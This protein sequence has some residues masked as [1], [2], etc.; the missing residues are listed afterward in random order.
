MSIDF[1]DRLEAD[2]REA[3]ERRGQPSPR[4]PRRDPRP[5]LKALAVAAVL[6]LLVVAGARLANRDSIERSA[7]PTPTP[8]P[9]VE[10]LG[11]GPLKAAAATS[12]DPSSL[13][14]FVQRLANA[15]A[16]EFVAPRNGRPALADPSLGTVVLYA[17]GA[18]RAA[19]LVARSAGIDRTRALM[20]AD[21][22]KLSFNVRDAQVVIVFGPDLQERTLEQS[23]N[24]TPAGHV[25]GGDLALCET[26]H[27]GGV[28]TGFLVNG[29]RLP[30]DAMHVRGHWLWAAA[31]PDGKTILADWTGECEV[32]QT[33]MI[34][35]A[36]GKP[37]PVTGPGSE[38]YGWTTDGRAIV[39]R[40]ADPGCS[41][42]S[43]PGLYLVTSQG[44]ATLVGKAVPRTLQ[45]TIGARDVSK[46]TG[47][48]AP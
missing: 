30:V 32:P 48:V 2:L 42:G 36:Q 39:G 38:A 31:S 27:N 14:F 13:D 33:F 29:Q 11:G 46:V 40:R 22:V 7:G 21:K 26:N 10:Q 28:V 5:V 24:C 19:E 4:R 20:A 35:V 6:A 9:T 18:K 17:D 25:T 44:E 12:G 23:G 45:R 3:A 15:P 43:A 16:L 1:L 47:G 34:D 8:T 37:R 41:D